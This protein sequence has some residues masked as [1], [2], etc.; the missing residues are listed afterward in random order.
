[1]ISIQGESGSVNMDEFKYRY[2]S[3][4][5]TEEEYNEILSAKDDAAD[6]NWHDFILESVRERMN[7]MLYCLEE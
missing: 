1:M 2:I 5:F 3:A 4:R 6:S 7:Y